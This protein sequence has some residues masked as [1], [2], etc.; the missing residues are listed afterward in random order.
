[1]KSKTIT[2]LCVSLLSWVMLALLT[3]CQESVDAST[4]WRMNNESSFRE[5]EGKENYKKV[6]LEGSTAYVYMKWLTH[7]TGTEYPIATSRIE[8]HYEARLLVND[9][10]FDG[11]YASE[12]PATFSIYRD[13]SHMLIEGVRIGLQ[14]MVVGDEA[15]III[16]WYLAYG[17]K[18]APS[19]NPYSALKFKMR[20]DRII[21]EEQV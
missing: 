8:C 3:S 14:N 4:Q 12:R 13:A 19:V 2:Y 17:A 20:L 15:E 10:L 21:P 6:S 11:N 5:Y 7:G 1:M 9:Y 16:P 18:G